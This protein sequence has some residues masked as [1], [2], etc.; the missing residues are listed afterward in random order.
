MSRATNNTYLGLT[1]SLFSERATSHVAPALQ[2]L[3]LIKW[4]V[5]GTVR[6]VAVASRRFLSHRAGTVG[7]RLVV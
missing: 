2:D 1:R 5:G 3:D 7:G 4:M 6:R